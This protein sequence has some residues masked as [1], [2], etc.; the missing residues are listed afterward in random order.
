M[1]LSIHAERIALGHPEQNGAHEQF[2][3]VLKAQTTRP[4]AR[5]LASQQRRFDRFRLEYND[6]RPHEALNDAVPAHRYQASPRPFPAR[7]PPVDYP[8]HWEPRPLRRV[9]AERCPRHP[10]IGRP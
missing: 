9:G 5:T 2:H 6:E 4:P 3:R 7:L 1:R 10:G 8:G